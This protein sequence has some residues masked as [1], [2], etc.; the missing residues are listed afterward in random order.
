[1]RLGYS[2]WLDRRGR[3]D[4]AIRHFSQRARRVEAAN[5]K[6]WSAS[7][8]NQDVPTLPLNGSDLIEWN[9]DPPR[10][11]ARQESM[12]ACNLELA[13]MSWAVAFSPPDGIAISAH[14]RKV[15][16]LG[17]RCIRS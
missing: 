1:M 16:A 5:L 3:G 8:R 9:G 10:A 6:S 4:K 2:R 17:L 12:E 11:A 7:P 15:P 13:H 14:C